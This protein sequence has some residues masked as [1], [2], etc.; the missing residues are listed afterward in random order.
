VEAFVRILSSLAATVAMPFV[1]VRGLFSRRW[2]QTLPE[3]FG[4]GNWQDESW[5]ERDVIW[6]HAASVGEVTGMTP[7]IREMQRRHPGLFS[8]VTTTSLS[9]RE[10]VARRRLAARGMIFPFDHPSIVKKVL[11]HVRPRLI[12]VAETE[13][14]PNFLFA[15]KD[16]GIPIAVVNGRMSEYSFPK[17]Y[18]LRSLFRPLLRSFKQIMVQSKTDA[19]RFAAVGAD[20]TR[21]VVTGSTKYSNELTASS[22][23]ERGNFARLLGVHPNEPCF[24]A[25]SVRSGED[26]QVIEAYALA[27]MEVPNLQMVIAPRHPERFD[28]VAGLLRSYGIDFNARSEGEPERP[29]DVVLLDTIGELQ[30]AYAVGSFA[31][32]GGSLVDIGGHNPF[33]PAACRA[34]IIF[35]PYRSNVKE[36]VDELEAKGGLF[37]VRNS[38]ELV[39]TIVRLAKSPDECLIR[40]ARAFEVWKKNSGALERVIPQL[41]Q[42]L[43]VEAPEEYAMA[44]A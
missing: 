43:N 25:G 42:L 10:E 14:W 31:F 16:L 19:D 8:V 36:I 12:V 32:V 44:G 5:L 28:R 38:E 34:P 27:K 30:R 33:E 23:D 37:V 17:Y 7:V 13:L 24:V 40:G 20:E 3:R 15:A 41:D 2:R 11:S 26:E 39:R 22:P 29:K 18:R 6:F 9:G 4:L 35:G 21:L 1:L